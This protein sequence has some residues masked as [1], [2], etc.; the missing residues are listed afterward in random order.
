MN[1][2]ILQDFLKMRARMNAAKKEEKPVKAITDLPDIDLGAK[3]TEI[4]ESK[5]SKK[6]VETY[7]RKKAEHIG[8][9]D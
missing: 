3:L 2:P 9:K 8:S 4:I 7:F 5:P 1:N 6:V